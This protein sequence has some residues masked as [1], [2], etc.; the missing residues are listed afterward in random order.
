MN[1]FIVNKELF[2]LVTS[3]GSTSKFDAELVG[4]KAFNLSK[5]VPLF[6]IAPGFCITTRAYYQ[7]FQP[8]LCC[9]ESCGDF[10]P[11][12]LIFSIKKHLS[13]IE[14]PCI[15]R[16]SGNSED[17]KVHSFAGIFKSYN[18]QNNLNE[19]LDAIKKCWSSVNSLRALAYF[20]ENKIEQE[21]FSM[22]VLIQENV[23]TEKSGVAFSFH[24]T[25]GDNKSI[26]IEVVSGNNEALVL[27]EVNP[28]SY[29]VDK[30]K[31]ITDQN[32]FISLSKKSILTPKEVQLIS[33]MTISL[34][35]IF[36][37]PQDIEWGIKQGKVYIFQSRPLVIGDYS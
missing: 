2:P 6:N 9:N 1:D 22:A 4:W 29:L 34:E 35:N 11:K 26:L 27:G 21:K 25:L 17:S 36:S 18:G 37:K 30:E 10:I 15:V 12:N 13:T 33:W 14:K 7:Y 31:I 23:N 28:S 3:L 5:L 19:V 8:N 32:A 24:P 16:S 20:R